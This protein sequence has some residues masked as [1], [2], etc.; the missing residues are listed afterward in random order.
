MAVQVSVW[1]S[2]DFNWSALY[3]NT[4]LIICILI[5]GGGQGPPR[6]LDS[7]MMMMILLITDLHRM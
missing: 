2:L 5:V 3:V 1:W 7:M 6:V 4:N